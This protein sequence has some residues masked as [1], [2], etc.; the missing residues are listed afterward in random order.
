MKLIVPND[1]L[2]PET[3]QAVIENFIT[4]DGAVH[5]HTETPLQVQI[6]QVRSQLQS[7]KAVIVYDQ[8]TESCTIRLTEEIRI[9]QT[10]GEDSDALDG[11]IES[12]EPVTRD[13]AATE[14]SEKVPEEWKAKKK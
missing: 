5:G 1:S 2:R 10:K 3:L 14:I 4:R 7:G 12:E 13:E 11:V 8:E 6:D 9:A